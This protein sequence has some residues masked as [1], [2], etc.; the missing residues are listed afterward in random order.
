M[1]IDTHMTS[2]YSYLSRYLYKLIIVL[3]HREWGE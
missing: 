3:S 1:K 2:F